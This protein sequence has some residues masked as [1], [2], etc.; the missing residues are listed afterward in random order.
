[1]NIPKHWKKDPKRYNPQI[2]WKEAREKLKPIF[3]EKGIV[4]CEICKGDFAMSFHHRHKR[5]EYIR[6][7]EDLGKFE[8]VLLLCAFC[9]EKLETDKELTKQWFQRLRK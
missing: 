8:E 7:K 3:M 6:H 1:M 9:H 2:V 4:R 5:W